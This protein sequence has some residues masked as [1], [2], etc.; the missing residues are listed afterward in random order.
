MGPQEIGCSCCCW[1]PSLPMVIW[2]GNE[3][4]MHRGA[5]EVKHEFYFFRNSIRIPKR[6]A[7]VVPFSW[8][9]I[10]TH[11]L[12]LSMIRLSFVSHRCSIL[13][14]CSNGADVS[15]MTGGTSGTRV[16]VPRVSAWLRIISL[17]K[18]QKGAC[19]QKGCQTYLDVPSLF[20]CRSTIF[21]G[22]SSH[23][24]NSTD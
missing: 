8:T 19:R 11:N 17:E 6:F 24:F 13:Y 23:N 3:T 14:C 7:N 22:P 10:F 21:S 18:E 20:W 12:G 4:E 9:L 2:N 5:A 1:V 16:L 15:L